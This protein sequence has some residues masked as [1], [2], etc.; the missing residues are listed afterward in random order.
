MGREPFLGGHE[1]IV[2]AHSCITFGLIKFWMGVVGYGGL[3]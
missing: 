3:L 2:Y 1:W